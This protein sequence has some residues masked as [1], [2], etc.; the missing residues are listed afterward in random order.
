MKNLYRKII[1]YLYYN[2]IEVVEPNERLT[3]AS[4]NYIENNNFI[5]FKIYFASGGKV[6]ETGSINR[7]KGEWEHSLHVIRDDQDLGESI[8]KIILL[9][10]LK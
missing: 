8:S 2:Q 7:K 10:G 9:E 5:S 3:S 6:V 1:K 4:S